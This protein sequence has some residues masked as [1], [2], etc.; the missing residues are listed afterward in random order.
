MDYLMIYGVNESNMDD[1]INEFLQFGDLVEMYNEPKLN[2]LIIKYAHPESTSNAQKYFKP[3]CIDP[4]F[5]QKQF[6][7]G[8]ISEEEKEYFLKNASENVT[9]PQMKEGSPYLNKPQAKSTF[10][11]FID[12]LF[13]V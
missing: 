4:V 12:V 5:K 7:F 2:W 3:Y 8:R 10:R 1:V 9:R 13:N 6:Q 11:K